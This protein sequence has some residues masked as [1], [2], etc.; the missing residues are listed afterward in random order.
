[1]EQRTREIK[2]IGTVLTNEIELSDT[3]LGLYIPIGTESE[4][5][6][7][8][9]EKFESWVVRDA[10]KLYPEVDFDK[11]T[12]KTEIDLH[13]NTGCRQV[14]GKYMLN[15]SVGFVSW[16]EDAEG[17]EIHWDMSDSFEIELSEED[18]NYIKRIMAHKIVDALI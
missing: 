13:I 4:K 18:R 3:C 7:A 2:N 15:F 5:I 11:C 8:E 6:K 17:N 14:D 16:F 1:M 10:K 12:L 9:R